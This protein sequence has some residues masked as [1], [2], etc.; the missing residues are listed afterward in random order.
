MDKRFLDKVVEQIVSESRV[1]YEEERI[2]V[3]FTSPFYFPLFRTIT[4]P[5]RLR[6]S[7]P[8]FIPSHFTNHCKSIYTLK[9]VQEIE[10]VWGKYGDIINKML[11]SKDNINES[12]GMDKKFLDKVVDQLVSETRLDY[13]KVYFPFSPPSP[14][15]VIR[16]LSFL[17][18]PPPSFSSH[19][20]EVYGLNEKEIEYVWKEYREIK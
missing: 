7:T 15:F 3:P 18:S 11:K 1:D 12:T 6:R 2:Y 10:Y 9:D 19:C 17:S 5:P 16:N 14:S 20:K 4:D 8:I 13:E